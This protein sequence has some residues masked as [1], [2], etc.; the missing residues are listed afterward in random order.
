[1]LIPITLL[2]QEW[3]Y[4]T[5][6]Y[7]A[8]APQ[9]EWC[10]AAA[11]CLFG[12][13]CGVGIAA[14]QLQEQ[15]EQ[16]GARNVDGTAKHTWQKECLLVLAW[17]PI[18]CLLSSP[19]V[20][21]VMS[22]SLPPGENLIGLN[23]SFMTF[24]Q[25]VIGVILYAMKSL[26]LPKLAQRIAKLVYRDAIPPNTAGRLMM[27]ATAMLSMIAPILTLLWVSQDCGAAWLSLWQ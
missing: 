21:Y 24:T 26:V 11:A 16:H 13:L 18:A 5:A 10:F 19:M 22:L 6:A 12:L 3:L 20:M 14:L 15:H 25:S 9:V 17:T 2:T 1:M 23:A 4:G 27:S 8:N 7:L